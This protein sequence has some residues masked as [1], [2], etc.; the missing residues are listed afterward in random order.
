MKRFILLLF[1]YTI[2]SFSQEEAQD[3]LFI[4]YDRNLLTRHLDVDNSRYYYLI[5]GTGN[6]EDLVYFYE[7][8]THKKLSPKKILSFKEVLINSDAYYGKDKL[9]DSRLAEY[10]W[11]YEVILVKGDDYIELGTVYEIE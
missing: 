4:K 3:T 8:E 6:R 10:L 5:K 11:K 1:F 2:H 9:Q 7:Y